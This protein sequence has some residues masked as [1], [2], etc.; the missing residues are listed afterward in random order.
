MTYE[1]RKAQAI[2]YLGKTADIEI[3]RPIGFIHKKDNYSLTYPINYGYIPDVIGG[4]GEELD[5]YLLGVSEPVK[6]YSAKII[7]IV[8]R[9]ND[10]EDKLIAAPQGSIY[11]QN[12]IAEA[13]H[14]QE[15]YYETHIEALYEK[16]S[17][18]VIYTTLNGEYLYLLIKQENGDIGFPKGHIE[19]GETEIEAA[20]R[21]IL[22]ETSIKANI[23]GDFREEVSYVMPNG[24]NKTAVYFT[25]EYKN[26]TPKHNDGYENNDYMLLSF[27]EALKA[28]TFDNVKSILKD[29]NSYLM[30]IKGF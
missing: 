22:E 29:A 20:L 30:N 16:S 15:Q 10:T 18:A 27:E 11:Y 28:I 3:D 9:H 12:E 7:G 25:A 23:I 1:E 2:S 8:H 5:V 17:G 26:Q 4:D 21:E 14:F 13:V 6:K 19:K 24:K